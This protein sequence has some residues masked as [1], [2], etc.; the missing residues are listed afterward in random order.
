MNAQVEDDAADECDN[1]GEWART[2]KSE[3]ASAL[4]DFKYNLLV[5]LQEPARGLDVKTL[6]LIFDDSTIYG[7]RNAFHEAWLV[8]STQ[9]TALTRKTIFKR[10]VLEKIPMLPRSVASLNWLCF[11]AG[12]SQQYG[13][14]TCVSCSVH[15]M[16]IRSCQLAS[17]RD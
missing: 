6:T 11:L 5:T 14:H 10:L 4:R 16:S 8:T 3:A 7:Q 2:N 1:D 15:C 17:W 9:A 13:A 12:S